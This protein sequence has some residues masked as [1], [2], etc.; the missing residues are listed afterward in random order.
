MG[1]KSR[2]KSKV[3]QCNH[4]GK[5]VIYPARKIIKGAKVNLIR[6]AKVGRGERRGETRAREKGDTLLAALRVE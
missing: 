5:K 6:G 3:S 2:C 4:Q 1:S